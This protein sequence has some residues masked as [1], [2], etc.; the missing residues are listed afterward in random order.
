NLLNV[1]VEVVPTDTIKYEIDKST[2]L[3]KVDRPQK[4]SNGGPALYGLVPQT[5]CGSR[6]AEFSRE[7]TGRPDIDGDQDPLDICVLTDR[8]IPHG[9][10]LVEAIPVGGFRMLDGGEADDKI[11]AVLKGDTSY[12]DLKELNECPDA[13]ID[14]LKH[15]FLTYKQKPSSDHTPCEITHTYGREE[16]E[17]VIERSRDDY[18]EIF[19]GMSDLIDAVLTKHQ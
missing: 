3:L 5:Y 9:N 13:I 16:A 12:G 17:E 8:I 15:Y 19:G 6:V 7:R 4:F 14:R 1:F 18:E 2:G 11:V 10:V